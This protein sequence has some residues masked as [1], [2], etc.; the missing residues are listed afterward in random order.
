MQYTRGKKLYIDNNQFPVCKWED[1][2]Y[3]TY[4]FISCAC[5][6]NIQSLLKAF[7]RCVSLWLHIASFSRLWVFGEYSCV[8]HCSENCFE[9]C[10]N[11]LLWIVKYGL[12]SWIWQSYSFKKMAISWDFESVTEAMNVSEVKK[13]FYFWLG[14]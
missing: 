10:S 2:R 5:L 13:N 12:I 8:V 3:F 1:S 7:W 9:F 6:Q 4:S 14:K 11:I